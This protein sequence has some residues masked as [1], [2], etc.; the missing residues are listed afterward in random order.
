MGTSK[1]ETS[2][3]GTVMPVAALKQNA[4]AAVAFAV[5][6]A[7]AVVAVVV[8]V[9]AVVVAAA[10]VA[11]ASAADVVPVLVFEFDVAPPPLLLVFGVAAPPLRFDVFL[12]A[13]L[14]VASVSSISSASTT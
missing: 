13:A 9:A 11:V 10:A 12:Q 3:E 6:A 7:V 8:A 14:V 5:V 4:R 1:E 2:K